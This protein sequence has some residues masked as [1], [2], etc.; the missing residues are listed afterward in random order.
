ML[1]WFCFSSWRIHHQL[2][3]GSTGSCWGTPCKC[4]DGESLR[5]VLCC[6]ILK[7]KENNIV[8]KPHKTCSRASCCIYY[9]VVSGQAFGNEQKGCPLTSH[10][11]FHSW[12]SRRAPNSVGFCIHWITYCRR[13]NKQIIGGSVHSQI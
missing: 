10:F 9:L 11:S 4:E 6:S 13:D 1:P 5:A 12:K 8:I 2:G 3:R 7:G